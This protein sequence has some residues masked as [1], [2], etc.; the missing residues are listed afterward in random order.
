MASVRVPYG[1]QVVGAPPWRTARAVGTIGLGMSIRSVRLSVISA[2]IG[3][4]FRIILRREDPVLRL[5]KIIRQEGG[6]GCL[7]VDGAS[8]RATLFLAGA[9]F[10]GA[11]RPP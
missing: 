7:W 4:L 1:D 6:F 10:G 2:R 3:D 11:S 8:L 5:F 9:A